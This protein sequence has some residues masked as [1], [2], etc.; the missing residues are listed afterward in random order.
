MR[1]KMDADGLR[2]LIR[3]MIPWFDDA[4][5]TSEMPTISVFYGIVIQM[6][7]GHCQFKLLR[8]GTLLNSRRLLLTRVRFLLRA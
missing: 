6:F 3:D 4:T 7:G 8:C 2:M 5:Q 1:W